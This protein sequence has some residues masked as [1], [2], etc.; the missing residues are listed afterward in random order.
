MTEDTPLSSSD[1]E[2]IKEHIDRSKRLFSELELDLEKKELDLRRLVFELDL[3]YI[4]FLTDP[5]K[6][7][8]KRL[9][10]EEFKQ[11]YEREY[12]LLRNHL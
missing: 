6:K 8:P 12:E 9:E 5:T 4:L 7:R 10:L 11:S 3:K 1:L 2:L